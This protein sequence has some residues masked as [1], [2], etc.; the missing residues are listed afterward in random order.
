MSRGFG[1]PV[2]FQSR[3]PNVADSTVNSTYR[4]L[5]AKVLGTLLAPTTL[6]WSPES[7]RREKPPPS[8]LAEEAAKARCGTS[9]SRARQIAAPAARSQG[10]P[11]G[12]PAFVVAVA[13]SIS[14]PVKTDLLVRVSGTTFLATCW[15]HETPPS[16]D[17]GQASDQRRLRGDGRLPNVDEG[18]QPIDR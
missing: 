7:P 11:F 3:I 16:R 18:R 5:T 12:Q 13:S 1:A 15:A 2:S 4:P 8:Q 10:A 6:F 17:E 9:V 14:R